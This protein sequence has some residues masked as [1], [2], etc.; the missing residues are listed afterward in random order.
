[1][2]NYVLVF[3]WQVLG[4]HGSCENVSGASRAHGHTWSD[5]LLKE[6][7]NPGILKECTKF[8]KNTSAYAPS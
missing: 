5:G 1:M 3:L 4:F 8:L 6:M 2:K 7:P